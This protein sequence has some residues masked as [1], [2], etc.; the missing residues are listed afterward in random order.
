MSMV[1]VLSV[2]AHPSN[3][4]VLTGFSNDGFAGRSALAA[5]S[6]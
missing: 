6:V 5:A 3:L 1:T 4:L 2:S